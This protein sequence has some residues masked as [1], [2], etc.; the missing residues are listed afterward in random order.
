MHPIIRKTFGGLTAGYYFRHLAF[1]AVA[2]YF[3][4][5]A[6]G[7][8][9]P[10]VPIWIYVWAGASALLYPFSRF[11]YESI[12][13][14]VLGDNIFALP[15]LLILFVKIWTMMACLALALVIAPIGLAWL[16]WYHLVLFRDF[17]YLC[18][19]LARSYCRKTRR[20]Y[21]GNRRIRP[22]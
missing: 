21:G 16:Y 11:V 8:F 19:L 17:Q 9:Q 3:L 13:A 5:K 20:K 1:S 15:I 4:N 22:D 6:T 18:L 10:P 2:L 12:V 7:V 14:F